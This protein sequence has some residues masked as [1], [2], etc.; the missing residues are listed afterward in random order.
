MKWFRTG[1]TREICKDGQN[2]WSVGG[3]KRL[4]IGLGIGPV[5]VSI[6]SG[7]KGGLGGGGAAR[8]GFVF[9]GE[10]ERGLR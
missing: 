2:V 4:R 3:C 1:K 9:S 5:W 8:I 6:G 10:G 7:S